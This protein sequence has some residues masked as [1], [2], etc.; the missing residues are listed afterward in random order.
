MLTAAGHNT[1]LPLIAQV[2][3]GANVQGLFCD[4][5]PETAVQLYVS[6]PVGDRQIRRAIGA[7][8]ELV[9]RRSKSG[10]RGRRG[11]SCAWVRS[12]KDSFARQ[13]ELRPLVP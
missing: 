6:L 10:R 5:T 2:F 4:L 1:I 7:L 12:P 8:A 3:V 13:F 9:R 11:C